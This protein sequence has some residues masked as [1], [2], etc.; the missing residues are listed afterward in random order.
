M[1]QAFI[2]FLLLLQMVG[3]MVANHVPYN[4]NQNRIVNGIEASISDF[5]H[6]VSLRRADDSKHFCGAAVLSE[7]WI[8]TAAQCTQHST[9][10]SIYIVVGT[11]N[12]TSKRGV[13]YDLEK[14]INH[15]EFNWEKRRNDISML[16]T[17][18]PMKI[19]DN[20][21]FPITLP[22]F[23]TNYIIENGIGL[24]T[25]TLSGWGSSHVRKKS[26]C[27]QILNQAF[28]KCVNFYL[29]TDNGNFEP[30]EILRF[31]KTSVLQRVSCRRHLGRVNGLLLN[32]NHL[33]T[34]IREGEGMCHGDIGS[35]L[36]TKDG[37]L[38]GIASW[39]HSNGCGLGYHIHPDVYTR[40]FPYKNWIWSN[41]IDSTCMHFEQ[42]QY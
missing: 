23:K 37:Q 40:I 28:R 29:Q 13:R 20:K 33:C 21:V 1:C 34:G 39:R 31:Q 7:F 8:L 38:V 42:Q 25:V 9:P 17:T 26:L 18:Q 30:S 19:S 16:K 3:L 5:P 15:P 12:L 11:A 24:T 32:E 36:I 2:K 6:Q 41:I 10:N 22:S 35:P 4:A 14:I 27:A